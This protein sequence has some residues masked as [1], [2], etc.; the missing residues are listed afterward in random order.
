MNSSTDA[1]ILPFR[2]RHGSR[3]DPP[4]NRWDD[5]TCR[6]PDCPCHHDPARGCER[7]WT[8]PGPDATTPGVRT[9]A[10]RATDPMGVDPDRAVAR[11]PTCKK[12]AARRA[13]T[14]PAP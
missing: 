14:T 7:G 10:A 4:T 13:A 12:H 3:A 11:C 1:G 8:G 6:V 5:P 2:R 9:A